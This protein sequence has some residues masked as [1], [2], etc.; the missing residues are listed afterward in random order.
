[1]RITALLLAA[2]FTAGP[3]ASQ[4][5]DTLHIQPPYVDAPEMTSSPGQPRGTLHSFIMRSA[6]SRIYPGVRQLD[7]ETT[8]RRDAYGNRLAAPADQQSEAAPYRR[9]V[10]V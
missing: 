6:D 10:F 3:G 7:N 5:P 8:R 9:E 1:M 2:V 4:T